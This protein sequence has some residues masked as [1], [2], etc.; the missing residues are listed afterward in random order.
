MDFTDP[1]WEPLVLASEA[2]ARIK[3][4]EERLADLE[5]AADMQECNMTESEDGDLWRFWRIKSD[6]H[7]ARA[8]ASEARVKRLV[9]TLEPFATAADGAGS[10]YADD[11]TAAQQRHI[12]DIINLGQLRRARAILKELEARHA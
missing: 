2:N 3:E 6:E 9:E 10:A 7:R 1:G 8:D 11:C 5:A 4:L 12:G